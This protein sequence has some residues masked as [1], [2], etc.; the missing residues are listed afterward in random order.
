MWVR[1]GGVILQ[2]LPYASVLYPQYREVLCHC[3]Y[4]E[5][6]VKEI[7]CK[8]CQVPAYCSSYCLESDSSHHS[9]ECDLL[10][11]WGQPQDDTDWLLLRVWLRWSAELRSEGE[12]GETVQGR[13]EPRRFSDFLS[14]E[15]DIRK[16][17]KMMEHV[18]RHYHSLENY[19][20]D[21]MPSFKEFI[22]F[23][24]KVVINDFE[25]RQFSGEN[26]NESLG[27]G[28]YLAPSIMDHSC[29]PNAEHEF[30]GKKMT[31]RS[32]K[33][34]VEP[35][36]S[37]VRIGYTDTGEMDGEVRR[38]YLRRYFFF[39]CQCDRCLSGA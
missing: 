32:L 29:T 3:C 18:T 16:S 26:E 33:D 39:T 15:E 1:K 37:M 34:L 22:R 8:D 17:S 13:K 21:D 35:D 24:G 4:T 36:M 11:S 10:S 28:V 25:L 12:D 6:Q 20:L 2:S 38:D 30:N 7:T 19:L 5:P 14:H 31:V 27:M 23:Y 9:L